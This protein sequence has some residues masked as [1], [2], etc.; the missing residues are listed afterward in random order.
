MGLEQAGAAVGGAGLF[1]GHRLARHRAVG[2]PTTTPVKFAADG[3][4]I[5]PQIGTNFRA[6]TVGRTADGNFF[7]FRMVKRA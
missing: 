2:R 4:G 7:A 3:R 6:A 5:A 1:N